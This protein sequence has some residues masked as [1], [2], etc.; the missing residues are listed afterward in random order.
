MLGGVL[1]FGGVSWFLHQTPDW[2]PA[3]PAV[4]AKLRTMGMVVGGIASLGLMILY[5][6]F[7]NASST[8]QASTLA[9]LAWALGESVAI[10]GG[11]VFFMTGASRWYIVGVLVLTLALVAFPPPVNR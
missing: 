4:A 10:F 3:D 8:S 11:V 6:R 9:I 2:V 5:T 7:R 1:L